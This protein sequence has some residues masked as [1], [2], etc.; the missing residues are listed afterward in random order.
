MARRRARGRHVGR[1]PREG[2]GCVRV[3]GDVRAVYWTGGCRV[4]M[5]SNGVEYEGSHPSPPGTRR[6]IPTTAVVATG[7]DVVTHRV[8][9]F[10]RHL[11]AC[12]ARIC[13]FEPGTSKPAAGRDP[14]SGCV[15]APAPSL[16][17][18]VRH[19]RSNRSRRGRAQR[20][21]V[22]THTPRRDDSPRPVVTHRVGAFSRQLRACSPRA[23]ESIA[24][25][26]RGRAQRSPVRT[27]TVLA[28]MIPRDRS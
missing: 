23:F 6:P 12:S 17:A 1:F 18:T 19:A 4:R 22:R 24:S 15:F 13:G 27:H 7:R 9:A 5:G 14:S 25:S 8:G 2:G 28:G 3:M 11:R 10:L 21:P 16:F 20:S 26:R